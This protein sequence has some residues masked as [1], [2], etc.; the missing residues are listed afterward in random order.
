MSACRKALSLSSPSPVCPLKPL[1]QG[2]PLR[3]VFP[4]G[5]R[6]ASYLYTR[7]HKRGESPIGEI[8]GGLAG[9]SRHTACGLALDRSARAGR[10]PSRS[11][12]EWCA[13]GRSAPARR[14]RSASH[15]PLLTTLHPRL[16]SGPQQR[17]ERGCPL[18]LWGGLPRWGFMVSTPS[19]RSEKFPLLTSHLQ[20][21]IGG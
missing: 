1:M 16:Y 21:F 19:R 20:V 5:S 17:G 13:R 7:R 9:W 15:V 10:L 8:R 6:R 11:V 4:R 3:L 18:R 2:Y 14:L 12:R